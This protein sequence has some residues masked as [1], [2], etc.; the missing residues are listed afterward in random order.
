MKIV[1]TLEKS[2]VELNELGRQKQASLLL[3]CTPM[4]AASLMPQVLARFAETGP[5][6]QIELVDRPPGEL[7]RRWSRT[8]ISMRR[9]ASSSHSCPG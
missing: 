4:I 2:V 3:G 7:L 5:Q 9:T 1:D 8:A 6:A